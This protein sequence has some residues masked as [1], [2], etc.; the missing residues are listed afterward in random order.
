MSSIVQPTPTDSG[1]ASE[2]VQHPSP[3]T[4]D[5]ENDSGSDEAGEHGGLHSLLLSLFAAQRRDTMADS[6]Q[7]LVHLLRR[8]APCAPPEV[9][10]A[11]EA[12]D[13]ARF[14]PDECRDH[15]YV[16]SPIRREHSGYSVWVRVMVMA[17]VKAR[18]RVRFSVRANVSASVRVSLRVS[19]SV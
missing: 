9:I 7:S 3:P 13:R 12:V 1:F 19:V 14:L 16:D 10:A 15:A 17:R 4:E 11:F 6:Q 8:R 18:A 2:A 5:E